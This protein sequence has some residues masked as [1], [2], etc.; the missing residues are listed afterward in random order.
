MDSYSIHLHYLLMGASLMIDLLEKKIILTNYYAK[1]K[2]EANWRWR[3]REIPLEHYDLFYVW[4][5]TG[6]VEVNGTQYP[7]SKGSCLLFRPG[8]FTSA[9]HDGQRPLTLTY[10][11]FSL[12]E[13]P[14][15]IPERYRE[16]KD[17]LDLEILLNRYVHVR[18]A[19]LYG[20]DEEA[21]LILKQLMIA[22]LRSDQLTQQQEKQEFR[23]MQDT[24]HEI[25]NFMREHPALWST[26]EDLAKRAQLSKSYF[27][28]KF[29]SYIGTSVNDYAIMSRLERAEYLLRYG[30]MTVTEVA[31]ALQYRDVYF[32]SR[33]FKQYMGRNPSELR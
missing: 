5:G 12:D 26:A 21:T 10:I 29:K 30:G 8:D 15:H 25:A 18:L 2:C 32:F 7:V 33:Q 22:L 3:A 24:I 17:T 19:N 11:H 14:N 31:D 4:D 1:I 13:R 23:A 28:K 6:Q 20:A 9:E 27:C 16:F